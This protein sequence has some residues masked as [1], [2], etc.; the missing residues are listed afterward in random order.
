MDSLLQTSDKTQKDKQGRI[1][2]IK[3]RVLV[4][5]GLYPQS[6]RLGILAWADANS[7]SQEAWEELLLSLEARG[8]YH[9]QGLE[10]LIHHGGKGLIAALNFIYLTIPHQRCAFHK[11]RN[12]WHTIQAP[13]H[14][15][16]EDKR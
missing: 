14:L 7:E 9:Q 10:L 16:R 3:V 15:S 8:L 4:A 5:L 1:R 13:D 6:Q 11:L 12:L 2:T